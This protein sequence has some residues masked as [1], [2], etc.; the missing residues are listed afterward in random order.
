MAAFVGFV[1][2][3]RCGFMRNESRVVRP[4]RQVRLTR[5]KGFPCVKKELTSI[6]P[7]ARGGKLLF[8]SL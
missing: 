7:A 5:W 4:L 1:A 6:V 8:A 3:R 2:Y